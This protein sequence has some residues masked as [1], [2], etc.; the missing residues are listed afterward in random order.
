MSSAPAELGV[1]QRRL[2]LLVCCAGLFVVSLD[3]TVLNVALPSLREDLNA[4]VS[5]VQWAVDAYTVVLASLLLL[6]GSTADRIG[7]RRVFQTGLTL[8]TLGSALCSLA[9]SLPWL[10]AARIFQ[11]VGGAMLNPVAMSIVTNTFPEPRER[12]RAIGWW[13]A[14]AGISMTTGPIIGGVLVETVGWRSIFWVNVPIGV[15]ALLLAAR[16]VP[17][18]RAARPRRADPVGQVLVV[19]LLASVVWAVIEAPVAGPASPEIVAAVVVAVAALI[20]LLVHEP[21]RREPLI[22]TRLFRSAPFSGAVIT[23]ICSFTALGGFLFAT[24]LHLQGERGLSPLQAG[25]HLVPMASMGLVA[26]PL[27]GRLL[28]ARGPRLPLLIAG[29]GLTSGGALLAV[30]HARPGEFFLHLAFVLFGIG[31]GFVNPPITNAAVSGLPRSRAGEA[32][33][34]AATS[35]QVGSALGVA[36]IGALIAAGLGAAA[37]WVIAGCGAVVLLLAG[38]TTGQRA[39]ASAARTADLLLAD[40]RRNADRPLRTG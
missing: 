36:V 24:T 28:A 15:A 6:A 1:R 35:R 18:S 19:A 11:A 38:V 8:F 40:E 25:L 22:E 4:S 31:F 3:N 17:E 29:A 32:A 33:A 30:S 2:V 9:P 16:H 26:A 37:W 34:V 13:S 23:A 5:G 39:A 7:R 10:V 21:R 14:V 27:S 12:A 20:G